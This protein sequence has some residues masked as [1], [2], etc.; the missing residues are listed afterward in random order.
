MRT[1]S[2]SLPGWK[3]R[4][5]TAATATISST[6]QNASSE[7]CQDISLF[8][9]NSG[10]FIAVFTRTRLWSP[11]SALSS[12]RILVYIVFIVQAYYT[13]RTSYRQTLWYLPP[14][15]RS[16]IRW[17]PDQW[18]SHCYVIE[19]YRSFYCALF[20]VFMTRMSS[21]SISLRSEQPVVKDHF[22]IIFSLTHLCPNLVLLRFTYYV[23]HLYRLLW[24]HRPN[25][26]W[27]VG[28]ISRAV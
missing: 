15:W 10:T 26:W 13:S 4:A 22:N 12:R 18:V 14:N 16:F 28:H 27:I 19:C 17:S 5:I 23:S 3:A 9:Q 25:M 24:F 20:C 2:I 1:L 6:E 11:S 8:L 21:C 7:I